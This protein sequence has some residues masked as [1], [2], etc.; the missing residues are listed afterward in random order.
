MASTGDWMSRH[1]KVSLCD[2]PAIPGT[3]NSLCRNAKAWYNVGWAW[4]RTQNLS[5]KQQ[6]E[7]GVR[8]LDVRICSDGGDEEEGLLVS[9]FFV[10]SCSLCG[11]LSE[12][13]AFLVE[14]PGEFVLLYLRKDWDRQMEAVPELCR[15]LRE[16]GIHWAAFPKAGLA[17]PVQQLRGSV[18]L[19]CPEYEAKGALPPVWPLSVFSALC[20]IWQCES[21][22][23]ATL[24]L[25][26]YLAKGFC[27]HPQHF[28]GFIID[29]HFPPLPPSVTAPSMNEHV[30]AQLTTRRRVGLCVVDF[31]DEDICKALV[32]LNDNGVT[33]NK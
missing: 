12:L 25:D 22:E 16:S 32:E 27:R 20:D 21:R 31:I 4:A 7:A 6:L 3:H 33:S 10:S 23:E 2:L 14:H 19:I 15:V 13:A 26:Q 11:L 29:G 24:K 18:A 9:H 17:T 8:Y 5:M 30:M 1:G 28:V